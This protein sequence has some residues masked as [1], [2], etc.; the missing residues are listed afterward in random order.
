MKFIS[1]LF[2]LPVAATA[3]TFSSVRQPTFQ[4]NQ[5]N[6]QFSQQT[7]FLAGRAQVVRKVEQPS[8]SRTRH[9]IKA[10]W[11]P[12]P[13]WE[14]STVISCAQESKNC[15]VVTVQTTA[16]QAADYK[17]SGQYLQFKVAGDDDAKPFFLAIA[18]PPT[19]SSSSDDEDKEN[20]APAEFDFLIKRTDNNGW[21]F[22][23]KKGENVDMSQVLGGGFPIAEN[24]DGL[25]YDFPTQNVILMCTGTGIAPIKAAIESGALGLSE[26]RSCR[27]Y[28]G[29]R[30]PDEMP[31]AGKFAKW[32]TLGVEVVPVISQPEGTN[33]NGRT[34]Y[35][36]TA[37]EEDGVPIPRNS[38]GLLCGQKEMA[39]AAKALLGAAGVFEGRVLTNF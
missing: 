16:E 37:L 8:Y 15:V 13:V 7:S 5:N 36:Q 28:Y 9:I 14:K 2:F 33:W 23:L 34:G 21:V 1:S 6:V 11:G 26:A 32:E 35:V 30:T 31:Y 17:V 22:D 24:L 20:A 12:D 29:A 18:T 4:A 38:C 19:G 10:G 27:L 3:F 39:E 25:K